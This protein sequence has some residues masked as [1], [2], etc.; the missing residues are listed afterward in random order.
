M[1]MV[2]K[3]YFLFFNLK[4]IFKNKFE[5]TWSNRLIFSFYF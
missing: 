2:F 4:T 3:S 5:N 1:T